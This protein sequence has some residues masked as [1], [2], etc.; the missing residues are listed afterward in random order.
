MNKTIFPLLMSGFVLFAASAC[1]EAK[2]TAS[3]PDS[4]DGNGKVATKQEI[5]DAK[6]DT[7]GDVRKQQLNA[8]IRA[9]EQR[10]KIGGD[11]QK[12]DDRDLTS[13]VRSKLEA[14]IP[15]GKLTVDIKDGTIIVAGT[16]QNQAQLNKIKP[17]AKE[18]KGVGNV[19]VKAIVAKATVK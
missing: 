1:N 16:V 12:R 5:K 15:E 7:Q 6:N 3:A 10:N 4:T 13:E 19:M 2:T 18:I 14:N 11:E 8:D 17:L 9:R